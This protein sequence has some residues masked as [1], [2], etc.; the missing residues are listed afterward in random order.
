[1]SLCDVMCECGLMVMILASHVRDPGSNPKGGI[2]FFL[3]PSL[4]FF[5]SSLYSSVS[6][7]LPLLFNFFSLSITLSYL[8]R[9]MSI[10]IFLI[11][12]SLLSL[13]LSLFLSLSISLSLISPFVERVLLLVLFKNVH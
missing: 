12:F 5:S 9:S 13:S 6:S 8:S 10:S 3:N 1:M 11:Y 7:V 2:L 4:I